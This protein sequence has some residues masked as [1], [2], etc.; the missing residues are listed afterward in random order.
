MMRNKEMGIKIESTQGR[1]IV[2]LD[3]PAERRVM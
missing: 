1:R 3:L 2:S